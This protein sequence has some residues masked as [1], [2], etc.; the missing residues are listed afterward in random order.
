M[1]KASSDHPRVSW[2]K[3]INGLPTRSLRLLT[4]LGTRQLRAWL[5][6]YAQLVERRRRALLVA[7]VLASLPCQPRLSMSL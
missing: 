3:M 2:V 6:H 4:T 5:K 7:V 1:A